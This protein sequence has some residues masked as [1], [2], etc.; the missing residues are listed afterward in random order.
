M[1][2]IWHAHMWVRLSDIWCCHGFVCVCPWLNGSNPYAEFLDRSSP[3]S[4]INFYL[5]VGLVNDHTACFFFLHIVWSWDIPMSVIEIILF[6]IKVSQSIPVTYQANYR[7]SAFNGMFF[8]ERS[9]VFMNF[10]AKLSSV[11]ATLSC[12]WLF[13]P[14]IYCVNWKHIKINTIATRH[15]CVYAYKHITCRYNI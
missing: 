15:S 7:S 1:C 9:V 4:S 2:V 12:R 3:I 14:L 13:I 5:C 6:I 8:D 10:D 11:H